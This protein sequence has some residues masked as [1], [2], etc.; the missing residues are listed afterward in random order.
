MIFTHCPFC[1]EPLAL[2]KNEATV[3]C[4]NHAHYF[5][6]KILFGG[7]GCLAWVSLRWRTVDWQYDIYVMTDGIT[8][9]LD[10]FTPD[11]LPSKH[12][13]TAI[14]IPIDHWNWSDI[15]EFKQQIQTILAFS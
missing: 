12:S 11:Y 7:N 10:D 5:N 3:A 6:F 14:K 8:I 15:N 4:T 9:H 1:Q 13:Y 2:D